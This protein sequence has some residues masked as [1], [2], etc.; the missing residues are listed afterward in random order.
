MWVF[1]HCG[2]PQNGSGIFYFYF[3]C[4][5]CTSVLKQQ[6]VDTIY[7]ATL[8]GKKE[9]IQ[10]RASSLLALQNRYTLT[11]Q[12]LCYDCCKWTELRIKCSAAAMHY[13]CDTPT[14]SLICEPSKALND[15]SQ[16]PRIKSLWRALY[17]DLSITFHMELLL[18]SKTQL[19]TGTT[20]DL[21]VNSRLCL[22][23]STLI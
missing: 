10:T 3:L 12:R 8:P 13:H 2:V 20:G 19:Y 7:T 21:S 15:K 18:G 22:F 16:Y 14:H 4:S 23:P 9:S 5:Y 17:G 1:D 6:H 11:T